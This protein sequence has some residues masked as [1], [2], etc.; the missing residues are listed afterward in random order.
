LGCEFHELHRL[1]GLADMP[2][3]F[4]MEGSEWGKQNTQRLH[5]PRRPGKVFDALVKAAGRLKAR[6]DDGET[7]TR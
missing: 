5:C 7:Q 4:I 1:L 6:G 3:A 2:R